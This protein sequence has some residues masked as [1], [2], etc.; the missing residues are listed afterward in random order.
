MA[1]LFGKL[2]KYFLFVS[3]NLNKLYYNLHTI[4]IFIRLE[5]MS[6]VQKT[7]LQSTKCVLS[8]PPFLQNIY[9]M[10]HIC[11]QPQKKCR[12]TIKSPTW[13]VEIIW[14]VYCKSPTKCLCYP[15]N[16]TIKWHN[17]KRNVNVYFTCWSCF[18][19]CEASLFLNS[20]WSKIRWAS[21]KPLNL[22]S[23][24]QNPSLR[25]NSRYLNT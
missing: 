11:F 7:K 13:L 25:F 3:V 1:Q 14:V 24:K 16:N 4:T 5:P 18:R 10:F 8:F 2:A 12:I 22:K 17:N 21:R 23:Q 19:I 20:I 6:K 15:Q 9:G